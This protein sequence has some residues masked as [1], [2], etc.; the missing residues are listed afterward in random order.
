MS[1]VAAKFNGASLHIEAADGE[2]DIV[3]AVD[4][5][6]GTE[7]H[8]AGSCSVVECSSPCGSSPDDV[9]MTLDSGSKGG[10]ICDISND[11]AGLIS[12]SRRLHWTAGLVSSNRGSG[13]FGHLPEKC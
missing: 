7:R 1:H 9:R 2:A 8:V 13:H 11:D 5:S 6:D 12:L 3:D 4:V 10:R